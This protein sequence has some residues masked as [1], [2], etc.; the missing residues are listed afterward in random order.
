MRPIRS[1]LPMLTALLCLAA[2]AFADGKFEI[3]GLRLDPVDQ[4][5]RQYSRPGF[6][7][8][9]QIVG[10]VPVMAKLIAGVGGFELVNLLTGKKVFID[11]Q[12]GLRVEQQTAQNYARLF[13]GGQV[14]SHSSGFV[15][16]YAGL[17][18][19]LVWY[20]INTDVVVPNDANREDEIRQ[21]LRDEDKFAFGW[22]ANT[23]I[24]FNFRDRWSI[25]TSVRYLHSYG[26]PQQLGGGAV[27]IQPSYVQ[28]KLGL[29]IGFAAIH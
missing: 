25:D 14:G 28:Y 11:P 16:P 8:G 12:T 17:N 13:A 6:G 4:D 29:G 2:P 23:G 27:T 1:A 5:A 19:A 18:V 3:Y 7:G 26:V 15:R 24:D 20:G 9:L 21:T 22:D 10:P